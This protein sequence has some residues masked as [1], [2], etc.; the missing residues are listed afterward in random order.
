MFL[1][2]RGRQDIQP[3]IAFVSTQMSKPNKSDW[4]KLLKLMG[5]LKITKDDVVTLEADDTE[6]LYWMVDAAFGVHADM[7][8]HTGAMF[9]LGKGCITSCST[10]QKVNARSSAKAELIGLDDVLSK[11]LWTYLF[12]QDQ[13][14]KICMN[15]VYRDNTSSMKLKQNGKESLGKQ[16]RH[17]NIKYFYITD[18]IK[19]KLV[20]IK[21]CPTDDMYADYMTKPTVCNKFK[22]FRD[23]IM[24]LSSSTSRSVLE[25]N[26]FVSQRGSK[27]KLL[28]PVSA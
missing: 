3:G 20:Q 7:K 11:I 9:T 25:N 21:Y 2:K 19:R 12:L 28:Q 6:T 18:L 22:M 15:L 8:S 13:W 1:C 27:I 4:R 23:W 26:H 17:F 24:N 5:F 16:T 14:F 10:K